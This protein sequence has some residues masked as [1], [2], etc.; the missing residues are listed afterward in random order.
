M[1]TDDDGLNGRNPWLGVEVR[2]LAALTAVAREGSF[3]GAADS[4]GYVQS[5]VSQQVAYLERV[6]GHKLFERRSGA[7]PALTSAGELLL[8]HAE[9]IVARL[10][11]A[12]ADLQ[13]SEGLRTESVRLG[14]LECTTSGVLPAMLTALHQGSPDTDIQVIQG[15]HSDDLIRLILDDEVDLAFVRGDELP[16]SVESVRLLSDPIVLVRSAGA[17]PADDDIESLGL[18]RHRMMSD[19]EPRLREAG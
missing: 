12:R 6:V 10:G 7:P 2:H 15:D 4:L 18:I 17:L 1:Y 13:A 11:A 19:F 3:R 5:A 8:G 16:P 9:E 14:T